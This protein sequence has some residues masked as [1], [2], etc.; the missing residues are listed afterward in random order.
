MQ[1]YTSQILSLTMFGLV[2]CE[3]RISL[4]HRRNQIIDGLRELPEK[5]KEVLTLDDKVQRISEELY[6][7]R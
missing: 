2:M 5:I 6:E 7:K 1:A 3:D 4:Q